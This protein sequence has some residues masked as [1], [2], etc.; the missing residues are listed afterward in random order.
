MKEAARV[1]EKASQEMR[2]ASWCSEMTNVQNAT[3]PT[4]PKLD[5]CCTKQ[6]Q[7]AD[8]INGIQRMFSQVVLCVLNENELF[9]INL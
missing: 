9:N 1:G 4:T 8:S 3:L 7:A 2:L 6:N 5:S